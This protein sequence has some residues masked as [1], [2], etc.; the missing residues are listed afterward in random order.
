MALLNTYDRAISNTAVADSA[1][2]PSAVVSTTTSA[3]TS[4]IPSSIYT[5]NGRP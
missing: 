3:I 1:P 2:P 4:S 5:T